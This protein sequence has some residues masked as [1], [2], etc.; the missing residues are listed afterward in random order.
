MEKTSEMQ[1]QALSESEEKKF[2]RKV[3]KAW[4]EYMFQFKMWQRQVK[5][6]REKYDGFGL[7]T[8]NTCVELKKLFKHFVDLETKKS[9]NKRYNQYLLDLSIIETPCDF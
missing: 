8:P 5:E 3:I 4:R 1:L 2:E 9:K 6:V 7:G